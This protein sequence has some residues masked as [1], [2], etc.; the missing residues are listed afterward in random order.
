MNILSQLRK[1]KSCLEKENYDYLQEL[2]EN[3]NKIS[4]II[5]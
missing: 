1:F 5:K 2:M 3:A 4:R